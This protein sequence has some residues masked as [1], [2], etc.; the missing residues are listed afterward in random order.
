MPRGERHQVWYP[1]LVALLRSEWR[2]DLSCEAIVALRDQMQGHLEQLR[3]R[4]DILPAVIHCPC[5]GTTAPAAPPLIS[6]RAMLFAVE[7]YGI[8]THEVVR[9]RER[10]WTGYR[11]LH[12]LDLVGRPVADHELEHNHLET[13]QGDEL[14]A[15]RRTT[16]KT[17][18]PAN[19][20]VE[21]TRLMVRAIILLRRAAHLER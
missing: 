13:H 11:A 17:E 21:P 6:V 4:R 19:I 20:K 15:L 18:T 12:D 7:R 1:E 8:E 5:C 9:Q 16:S 10:A 2:P 14:A 3:A